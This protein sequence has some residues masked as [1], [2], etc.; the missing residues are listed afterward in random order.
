MLYTVN[1]ST[2]H[3]PH[4]LQRDRVTILPGGGQQRL[5]GAHVPQGVLD[6]EGGN[7]A[8]DGAHE[9]LSQQAVHIHSREVMHP[10]GPRCAFLM[11]QR[12]DQSHIEGQR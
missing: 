10:D 12:F 9:V 4:G 2:I 7:H 11:D 1:I 6:G 5:E 8:S 3:P